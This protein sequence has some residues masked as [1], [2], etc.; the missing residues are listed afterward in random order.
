MYKNMVPV[1]FF[2]TLELALKKMV[3]PKRPF[4]GIVIEATTVR[5]LLPQNGIPMQP[6]PLETFLPVPGHGITVLICREDHQTAVDLLTPLNDVAMERVGRAEQTLRTRLDPHG[7]MALGAL[8]EMQEE[9]LKLSA[10]VAV[11]D[12]SRILR[13]SATGNPDEPESVGIALETMLKS[14]GVLEPTLTPV[15]GVSARA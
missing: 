3:H 14:R 6:L 15:G 4:S 5:S 7:S 12:G 9:L 2:G 1:E 10:A 11:P 8:G 13:A